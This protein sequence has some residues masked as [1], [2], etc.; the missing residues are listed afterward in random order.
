MARA[1]ELEVNPVNRPLEPGARVVR[2]VLVPGISPHA[3]LKH[4]AVPDDEI[5]AI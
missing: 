5:G 4:L 2:L 1:V 3:H